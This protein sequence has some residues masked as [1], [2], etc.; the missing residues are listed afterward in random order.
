MSDR[1]IYIRWT[2]H[3]N[4]DGVVKLGKASNLKD[5]ES[6]YRTGEYY[7]GEFRFAM[8]S[9]EA[10]KVAAL[11]QQGA[12]ANSRVKSDPYPPLHYAIIKNRPDY[13]ELLLEHGAAPNM[14][15][16]HGK[17]PL[18]H[19]ARMGQFPSVRL[20]LANGA[21]PQI[22]LTKRGWNVLHVCSFHGF[23][24]TKYHKS[25]IVVRCTKKNKNDERITE[26]ISDKNLINIF[27]GKWINCMKTARELVEK[28]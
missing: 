8:D 24:N 5:R 14:P 20:L 22:P 17:L 6:T 3:W 9:G 1:Y 11:L 10:G 7:P 26:L 19:A 18:H 15:D 25:F 28:I 13:V 16:Q 27:S 2:K 4:E 12:S 21:N 23:E